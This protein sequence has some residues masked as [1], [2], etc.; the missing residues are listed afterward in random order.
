MIRLKTSVLLVVTHTAKV[1]KFK[2][3][4]TETERG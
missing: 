1:L 4:T 3:I 2:Q